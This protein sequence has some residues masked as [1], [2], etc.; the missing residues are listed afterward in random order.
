MTDNDWLFAP[1][2]ATSLAAAG[3][4][5]DALV[6]HAAAQAA[7]SPATRNL[8]RTYAGKTLRIV[9]GNSP[10]FIFHGGILQGVHRRDRRAARILP[11]PDRRA[12]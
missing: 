8:P 11:A 9:W 6:K 2:F 5:L 12:L 7:A 3:L 4:S 1:Q 10:A